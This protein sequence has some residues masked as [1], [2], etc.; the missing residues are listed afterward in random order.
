[1]SDDIKSLQQR[2]AAKWGL[3]HIVVDSVVEDTDHAGVLRRSSFA[4]HKP[5]IGTTCIIGLDHG[6]GQHDMQLTV[7]MPNH[8]KRSTGRKPTTLAAIA[9][10]LDIG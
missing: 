9:R 1:M 7:Q 3:P 5:E 2:A 8:V 6:N 4:V 10:T